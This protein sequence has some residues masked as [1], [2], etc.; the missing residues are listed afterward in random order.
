MMQ[1][2][3][4][5]PRET[6]DES[7]IVIDGPVA[8]WAVVSLFIGMALTT[9]VLPGL[10]TSLTA[11]GILTFVGSAVLVGFICFVMFGVMVVAFSSISEPDFE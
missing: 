5:K 10:L 3:F 8:P 6:E 1:T 4:I 9:L 7:D 11:A 2:P